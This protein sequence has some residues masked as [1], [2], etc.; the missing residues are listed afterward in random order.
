MGFRSGFGFGLKRKEN[1]KLKSLSC[2]PLIAFNN[3]KE[4]TFVSCSVNVFVLFRLTFIS[5]ECCINDKIIDNNVSQKMFNALFVL[6]GAACR[7]LYGKSFARQRHSL[8]R[9]G[10]SLNVCF[11]RTK[12]LD[13]VRCVSSVAVTIK[14]SSVNEFTVWFRQNLNIVN[15]IVRV[16]VCSKQNFE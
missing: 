8:K 11:I 5:H 15:C 3:C 1:W 6:F 2:N 4:T 12:N 7:K 13:L 10:R 14:F 9:N 16:S